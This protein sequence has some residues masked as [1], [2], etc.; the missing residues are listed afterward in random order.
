[1]YY[2][3]YLSAGTTWFDEK[4]LKSILTISNV[5]NRR[6]NITGLLL[7][8]LGNFIQLLEGTESDVRATFQKIS[9]DN[10]HKGITIVSSGRLAE[11]N[12]P[13][14]AMGFKTLSSKDL[15]LFDGYFNPASENYFANKE[16]HISTS[17]LKAF[18]QTARIAM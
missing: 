17:L 12:F 4:E 14:W 6:N 5:N 10:R 15:E 8:S 18:V 16:A 9:L 3:L 1:M 13:Q 7:Y 2:I 11:R